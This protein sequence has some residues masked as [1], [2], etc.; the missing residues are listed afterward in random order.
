MVALVAVV[1][2]QRSQHRRQVP[3]AARVA[4]AAAREVAA[5]WA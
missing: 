2:E 1:A 5:A 3:L 4:L